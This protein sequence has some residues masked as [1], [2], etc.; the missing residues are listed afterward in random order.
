MD[1]DGI[2]TNYWNLPWGF[3][4]YIGRMIRYPIPW[5]YRDRWFYWKRIRK[6][7]R[8]TWQ[9]RIL[10]FYLGRRGR[11]DTPRTTR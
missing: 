5:W 8:Y 6:P 10:W 1:K 9:L 11:L 7:D 4:V 2:I 3:A